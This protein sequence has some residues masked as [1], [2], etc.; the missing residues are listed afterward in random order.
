MRLFGRRE[1]AIPTQVASA[2]TLGHGD[3]VLAWARDATT[4]AYVVASL[5]ALHQVCLLY[6]SRCV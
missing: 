1:P 4:G 6:T 3:R 2:L 5:H